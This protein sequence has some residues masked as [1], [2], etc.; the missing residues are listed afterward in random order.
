M[1]FD[2]LFQNS[3]GNIVIV[4]YFT[5]LH[6]FDNFTYCSSYDKY[7]QLINTFVLLQ[8]RQLS[9]LYFLLIIIHFLCHNLSFSPLISGLNM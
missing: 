1:Y 4:K 5:P 2:L 8:T 7:N 9:V 3:E 6:L